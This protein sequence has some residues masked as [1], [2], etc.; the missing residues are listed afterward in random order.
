MRGLLPGRRVART[1]LRCRSNFW[2]LAACGGFSR[3]ENITVLE[4]RCILYAVQYAES[5]Y[6]LGRLL[7]L[8]DNFAL[9]PALCRGRS[10]HFDIAFSH[11]S[12]LCVL[13]QSKFCL[14]VQVDTVR[15]G[16][17]RRRKSFLG[18]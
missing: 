12:D 9:V 4:A 5:R 10:K 16:L 7:I 8:S 11:A 2:T 18:P 3:C 1:L 15:F 6:P 14:I 17:F 13:F